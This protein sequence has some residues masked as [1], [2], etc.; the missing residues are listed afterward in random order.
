MG[1][2]EISPRHLD[3][4][5]KLLE[6]INLPP[7]TGAL[8]MP[9]VQESAIFTSLEWNALRGALTALVVGNLIM[10][11]A[12]RRRQMEASTSSDRNLSKIG[13]GI[14]AIGVSGVIFVLWNLDKL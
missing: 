10:G 4:K 3:R 6:I 13:M 2:A 12:V 11:E 1:K 5:K 7:I 8:S 14:K 9:S